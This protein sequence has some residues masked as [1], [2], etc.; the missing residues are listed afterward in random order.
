MEMEVDA[1]QPCG[2]MLVGVLVGSECFMLLA[3]DDRDRD[4]KGKDREG[5]IVRGDSV[6]ARGY[7]KVGQE[8]RCSSRDE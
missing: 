6:L 1:Q 3:E 4:T 8:K 5:G 7:K 2:R